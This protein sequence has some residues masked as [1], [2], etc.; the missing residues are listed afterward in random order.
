M[1]LVCQPTSKINQVP[2]LET[3][4]TDSCQDGGCRADQCSVPLHQSYG[5][6]RH[7]PKQRGRFIQGVFLLS[8]H[9]GRVRRTLRRS[10]AVPR[11]RC[12]RRRSL[13]SARTAPAPQVRLYRAPDALTM[14]PAAK[15]V[16]HWRFRAADWRPPQ[17]Q[18]ELPGADA[19]YQF[20]AAIGIHLDLH[21]RMSARKS[22]QNARGHVSEKSG[23]SPSRTDPATREFCI[24]LN[25]SSLMLSIRRA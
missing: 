3:H 25:T 24:L 22:L 16:G 11:D 2:A 7:C 12:F 19:L 21:A 14:K 20:R 1:I 4:R 18:I 9:A 6:S 23:G 10:R 5:N 15:G 17:R 13:E 8:A